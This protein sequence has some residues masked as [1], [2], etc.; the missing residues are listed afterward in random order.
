MPQQ[1]RLGFVGIVL[2]TRASASMVN[3]IISQHAAVIKARVGVPD[4]QGDSAVIGLV[5]QGEDLTLGSLTA[6][7]GNIR[8]VQVKSA[9]T[10]NTIKQE[11]SYHELSA[12]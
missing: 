2:E 8:G 6:K 7:L 3:A 10:K 1:E 4:A 9:L 12:K 11:D 5:V